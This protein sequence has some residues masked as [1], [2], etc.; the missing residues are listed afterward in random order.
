MKFKRVRLRI[1]FHGMCEEWRMCVIWARVFRV[2]SLRPFCNPETC[3]A[4][5]RSTVP[6]HVS[7]CGERL[8]TCT[9]HLGQPCCLRLRCFV[10]FFSSVACCPSMDCC[11][12]AVECDD[13]LDVTTSGK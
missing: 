7:V 12:V 1:R 10:A 13:L 4:V 11:F 6:L 3:D 9:P 8:N 2:A 5:F